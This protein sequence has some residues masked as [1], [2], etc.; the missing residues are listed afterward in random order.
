MEN[1][2]RILGNHRINEMNRDNILDGNDSRM[3][4]SP[5]VNVGNKF[6]LKHLQ[7]RKIVKVIAR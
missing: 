3:I 4:N 6:V 5:Q 1:Q 7:Q 2:C